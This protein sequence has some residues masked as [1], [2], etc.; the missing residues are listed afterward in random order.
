MELADVTGTS[1]IPPPVTHSIRTIRCRT[2]L[3]GRNKVLNGWAFWIHDESKKSLDE[4]RSIYR[5][6]YD[7]E[8]VEDLPAPQQRAF[9]IG[10][11][12]R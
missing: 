1:Q 4:L 3:P 12:E 9:T 11:G 6:R 5:D 10:Q 8:E 2:V 7:I